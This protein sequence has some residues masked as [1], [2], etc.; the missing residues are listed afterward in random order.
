[1]GIIA[2][3]TR[4]FALQNMEFNTDATG[5]LTWPDQPGLFTF[6]DLVGMRAVVVL[7]PAWSGKT[8]LAK[9]I[10]AY[11]KEPS[12]P[13]EPPHPFG[14]RVHATFFERGVSGGD[15]PTWWGDSWQ[16]RQEQRACWIVDAIDEDVR[17]KQGGFDRILDA[18]ENLARERR[19]RLL[20]L[21]FCRENEFSPEIR[22]RLTEI[23]GATGEQ[24]SS[25]N[26]LTLA[27]L[28]RESA[29]RLVAGGEQE[30]DRVCTLAEHNRI[31]KIT[32]TP[33][34]LQT[35]TTYQ[36]GSSV[37]TEELWRQIVENLLIDQRELEQDPD[38]VAPH[39]DLLIESAGRIAATLAFGDCEVVKFAGQPGNAPSLDDLFPPRERLYG[40]LRD[41]VRYALRSGVFVREDDGYRVSAHNVREWLS[42]LYIRNY[43]LARLRPLVCDA[44]GNSHPEHRGILAILYE[45]AGDQ[46][47]I[48]WIAR[49]YGGVPPR[50]DALPWHLDAAIDCL[51]N[52]LQA[53]DK[54]PH[55]LPSIEWRS[56]LRSFRV[57]GM[58]KHVGHLLE[59][60]PLAK[61]NQRR[62]LLAVA[63]AIEAYE[64][65]P[66]LSR[67]ILS[68]DEGPYVRN[69]AVA[70]EK[71]ERWAPYLEDLSKCV[72]DMDPEGDEKRELKADIILLLLKQ[73][74][75]T[76]VEAFRHMPEPKPFYVDAAHVLVSRIEEAMSLDDAR[77]IA[78]SYLQGGGVV[79]GAGNDQ[80][81]SV[82]S[83]E[84]RGRRKVA[85]RALSVLVKQEQH[86]PDDL[87]ILR[88]ALWGL[89]DDIWRTECRGILSLFRGLR[90]ER[91]R[92]VEESLWGGR[93]DE[94][95][96]VHPE[97]LLVEEDVQWLMAQCNE[98]GGAA[99]NRAFSCL[100]T[101]AQ[102]EGISPDD[103]EAVHLWLESEAA[104]YV[105]KMRERRAELAALEKQHEEERSQA[106]ER[107][108]R[109]RPISIREAVQSELAHR[110]A[111]HRADGPRLAWVCFVEDD[112]LRPPDVSGRWSDLNEDEKK[113]VLDAC[114][115]WVQTE[116]PMPASPGYTYSLRQIQEAA[117]FGTL[118]QARP[119]IVDVPDIAKH[120][121]PSVLRLW[122][123]P[124]LTFSSER[125]L[126]IC[127]ARQPE[128]TQDA[129]LVEIGRGAT[130][131]SN[132]PVLP[133]R[134]P[135]DTW[136]NEFCE[137]VL[138][139]IEAS[140]YAPEARRSLLWTLT[141]RQPGI[142]LAFARKH[143][144]NQA[145]TEHAVDSVLYPAMVDTLLQTAPHD[146]L[147][148]LDREAESSG[149]HFLESLHSLRSRRDWPNVTD[150]V[151]WP[152]ENLGRLYVVLSRALGDEHP[153]EM[154]AGVRV[155]MRWGEAVDELRNRLP[156]ILF[157]R[158]S[159]D[160][161]QV[162]AALAQDDEHL[163]TWYEHMKSQREASGLLSSE[164]EK[165]LVVTPADLGI[166]W[167]DVVE[168]LLTESPYRPIQTSSDLLEVLV[169]ELR[170][171]GKDARQ[172][173]SCLYYSLTL[174][175]DTKGTK[176]TERHRQPEEALQAYL[177]C[178][179]QDRLPGRVLRP[180]TEIVMNRE[181]LTN[182]NRR[183]DIKAEAPV[184][185]GG[186]VT[187]IVELKWSDNP[188]VKT[189]LADQLGKKYL[190]E[191]NLTHGIYFVAWCGKGSLPGV[192]SQKCDSRAELC[193][194][195]EE[196]FESQASDFQKAH[197]SIVIRPLVLN[198]EWR[199][200]EA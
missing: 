75:W 162:L 29:Y 164:S 47:V 195:W 120:W 155:G 187:V 188:E 91:R 119:A 129:I 143:L 37:S 126:A 174:D 48:R 7:A 56:D 130:P 55:G 121:L 128:E 59:E 140:R 12:F 93:L 197:G 43:S 20:L 57:D 111:G 136:G 8:T 135:E 45:I 124:G 78:I 70:F 66:I 133:S 88:Q 86:S 39:R 100:H 97:H 58:A 107:E 62:L 38:R 127:A 54:S 9:S 115:D 96:P 153:S 30:L 84:V 89:G 1:M 63:R 132:I 158:D 138:G 196:V 16:D 161:H 40:E 2:P 170:S 168:A 67:I 25:L 6:G 101:V 163:S 179:L 5:F 198:L 92:I 193:R 27:P 200:E 134:L 73:E 110:P 139:V 26:Y 106:E 103:R 109:H 159:E 171:I 65:I 123:L 85:L 42:A 146:V 60:T 142:A 173:L 34:V 11:L 46:D 79:P 49:E 102:R 189:A 150:M 76:C 185:S 32:N 175:A 169:E 194:K 165:G 151:R 149:L 122:D 82:S 131:P 21:V 52:L 112:G 181:P 180:G 148:L 172:H 33:I 184:V 35:L 18:I 114:A 19:E 183:N 190:T 156:Y 69:A 117:L 191:A 50:T 99:G 177:Y 53:A 68:E 10:W 137:R 4:R 98:H 83:G 22:G 154:Q 104:D 192:N 77:D 24:T 182:Q 74:Y 81:E 36:S 116:K 61:N 176:K 160:S 41:A 87:G 28:D 113:V 80:D 199:E 13:V 157:D 152:A 105:E 64:L 31:G 125:V 3:P 90:D 95:D 118:V 108:A 141:R 94:L 147:D 145:G 51:R 144:K 166:P 72:R 178:R 17:R 71:S 23:Y 14:N 15:L 167:R 44:T 186:R